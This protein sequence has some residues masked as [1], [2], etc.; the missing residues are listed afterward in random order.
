LWQSFLL[1][2]ALKVQQES[3]DKNN[4][5]K[6]IEDLLKE[7]DSVIES[8]EA[9]L[10]EDRLW[11]EKQD[12]QL[13]EQNKQLEQLSKE[14]E[15]AKSTFQDDMNRLNHEAEDLKMKVKVEAEK[16][17]KLSE[18]L[19]NLW[20]TCF[21]FVTRC[22]SRLWE[23]FNSVGAALEEA[24]LSPDDI[25]KALE[26]IEKEVEYFD[27]VMVGHGDFCALVAARGTAAIFAKA[28]CDH[29]KTVNKPTF[30]ISPSDLGEIPGEAKSVGNRFVT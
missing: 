13:V 1:S 6:N 21:G 28:R 15:R 26:W 23:I 12:I 4:E 2:K 24:K 8:A 14:F 16:N 9:N 17:T 7:N 5:F 20:D 18:V 19:K 3:D 29:L 30:N 22:F 27:K 11:N 25:P 10:A